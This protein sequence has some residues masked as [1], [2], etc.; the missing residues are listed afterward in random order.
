MAY[1]DKYG[2]E[3][4]DDRKT[5]VK[6]P[7]DFEGDYIVP[8]G[9]EKI[10]EWAFSD[11]HKLSMITLSEGVQKIDDYAFFEC[12]GL[13][14]IILPKSV[15]YIG[16]CT[17]KGCCGLDIIN[18]PYGL[19]EIGPFAFSECFGLKA[20][21]IPKS[22]RRINDHAFSRCRN[23]ET[24]IILS[25][26]IF[27]DDAVFNGCLSL[28]EIIVPKG[29][30]ESFLQ[31][32]SLCEWVD[33]IKERGR[34]ESLTHSLRTWEELEQLWLDVFHKY[35]KKES[36][37][38]SKMHKM[39]SQGLVPATMPPIGVCLTAEE[40]A[41]YQFEGR[42]FKKIHAWC[43][44]GR[45][46]HETM[47]AH[48]NT[49]HWIT[50]GEN[51]VGVTTPRQGIYKIVRIE[52]NDE[53]IPVKLFCY[54]LG[55]EVKNKNNELDFLE[56]IV[57]INASPLYNYYSDGPK[58]SILEVGDIIAVHKNRLQKLHRSSGSAYAITWTIENKKPVNSTPYHNYDNQDNYEPSYSQYGGYN[59]FDD[60]TINSAFE[61]DPEATWNV[62]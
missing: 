37:D 41:R 7:K 53:D 15:S 22:V 31:L 6:C 13:E 26:N 42:D 18:L 60:D 25:D 56:E 9:I 52:S 48:L 43:W 47:R 14:A 1:I 51:I 21:A 11:C 2:V 34:V 33:K 23:L 58:S 20:I 45:D 27:I 29:R 3:F 57:E 59:G 28:Q 5:L 10:A 39:L 17:F 32:D 4:T 50:Y 12:C 62:D 38:D 44:S 55:Q 8:D 61:G 54:Y 49:P 30:K 36:E 40:Y 46:M 24:V 19:K 16:D 35:E